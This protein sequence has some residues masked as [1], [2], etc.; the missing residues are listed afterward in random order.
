ME[1]YHSSLIFYSCFFALFALLIYIAKTTERVS[2]FLAF[3]LW[4]LLTLFAG[5]RFGP[6]RDFPLYHNIYTF[7]EN[8]MSFSHLEPFWQSVILL[9]RSWGLSYAGWFTVVAGITYALIIRGFRR[10]C[11]DNWWIAVL[12]FVLI[13][14]GYFETYN[15]VRQYVAIAIML[16]AYPLVE[17]RRYVAFVLAI[18]VATM[19]HPS[20]LVAIPVVLLGR[21][22]WNSYLLGGLLLLSPIAESFVMEPL[23]ELISKLL[24]ERYAFYSQ[25]KYVYEM[26][27]GLG[28]YPLFLIFVGLF[29]LYYRR[30]IEPYRPEIYQYINYVVFAAILY[31]LFT[32]F[33]VGVRIFYY[34]FVFIFP[35]IALSVR[36]RGKLREHPAIVAILLIFALFQYK[37]LSNTNEPYSK[38]RSIYDT[39]RF[40][41]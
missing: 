14:S 36:S 24:P 2:A 25:G 17:Q 31:N 13:Y 35:L 26:Q 21:I 11:G 7:G 12:A 40:H 39:R 30:Y 19:V 9:F 38:Y 20:A 34:P 27:S 4:L 41:L 28:V 3:A 33:E 8:N 10:L 32:H 15:M 23:L 22:R 6:G 29:F 5:M 16:S 1:I 37:S 18:G